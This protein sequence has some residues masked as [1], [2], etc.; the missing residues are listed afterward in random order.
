MLNQ[1]RQ[2]MLQQTRLHREL[3]YPLQQP[4]FNEINALLHR[5][6]IAKSFLQ[7]AHRMRPQVRRGIFSPDPVRHG[8]T[9]QVI[10]TTR[11]KSNTEAVL[12]STQMETSSH[13]CGRENQLRLLLSIEIKVDAGTAIRRSEE[14]RVGEQ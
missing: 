5:D 12:R 3:R 13:L 14:R 1:L 7:F 9:Q 8:Q 10:Y 4:L 6:Q 2:Q 11:T